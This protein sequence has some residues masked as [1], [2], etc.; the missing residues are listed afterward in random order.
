MIFYVAIMFVVAAL[1]VVALPVALVISDSSEIAFVLFTKS[2]AR[3]VV[4]IAFFFIA[5]IVAQSII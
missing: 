2:N 3:T 4:I 5:L 1:S